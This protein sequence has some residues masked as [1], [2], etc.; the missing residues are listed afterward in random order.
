MEVPG[1][2]RAGDA[3]FIQDLVKLH[4]QLLQQYTNISHGPFK[5]SFLHLSLSIFES[6]GC[7]FESRIVLSKILDKN[8]LKAMPGS[9]LALNSGSFME[10]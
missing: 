8:G 9:I 5:L 10:K 4:V 7:G 2:V 6:E 1:R 3:Q